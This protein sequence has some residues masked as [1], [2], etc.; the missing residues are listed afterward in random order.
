MASKKIDEKF[1]AKQKFSQVYRSQII[2]ITSG[3]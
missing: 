3:Y 2:L 1:I